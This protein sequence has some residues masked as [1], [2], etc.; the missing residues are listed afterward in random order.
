MFQEVLGQS[1]EAFDETFDDFV[2]DRWGDRMRAVAFSSEEEAVRAAHL[3]LRGTWWALR[4]R[5]AQSPGNFQARLAYGRALF[6]EDR[7]DEAEGELRAALSLFPEY[8]GEDSP[9]LYLA[10]IHQGAG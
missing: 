5:S 2:Q 3:A 7:F 1:P 10:G 4:L 8:G 6:M 9:Y